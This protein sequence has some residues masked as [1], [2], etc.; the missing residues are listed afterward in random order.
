M[1]YYNE[2]IIKHIVTNIA[3]GSKE[4]YT[5]FFNDAL[6]KFDVKSPAGLDDDKKKDFF[7]YIEKNYKG[8]DAKESKLDK[9]RGIIKGITKEEVQRLNEKEELNSDQLKFAKKIFNKAKSVGKFKLGEI[10]SGMS[11]PT[12]Q[13]TVYQFGKSSGSMTSI[14]GDCFR[15]SQAVAI[16]KAWA[17]ADSD[18]QM[19]EPSYKPKF[20]IGTD[21]KYMS[22]WE[23]ARVAGIKIDRTK[24]RELFPR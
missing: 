24:Y 8:D 16:K 15:R 1:S 5:K 23:A 18:L 22:L 12:A 19:E 13:I 6:K 3:E 14:W 11:G 7:N 2:A 10:Y 4:E 9:L 17:D 20:F 21:T